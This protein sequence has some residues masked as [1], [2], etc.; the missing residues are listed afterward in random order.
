MSAPL[1]LVVSFVYWGVAIDQLRRG[2]LANF[3]VWSAYGVAN[4]GLI[5]TT[6]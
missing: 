6:K 4:W 1:L 5:W 3:V 2:S